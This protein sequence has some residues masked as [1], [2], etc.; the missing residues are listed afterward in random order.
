MKLG[1]TFP[2]A[3]VVSAFAQIP[4]AVDGT[5]QNFMGQITSSGDSVT[6]ISTQFPNTDVISLV[7]G[8]I[9]PTANGNLALVF[10]TELSTTAG[11]VIKQGTNGRLEKLN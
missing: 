4:Q 10:G 9:V 6:S 11:V 2:A 8:S 7:E 1:L 3:A 5:A